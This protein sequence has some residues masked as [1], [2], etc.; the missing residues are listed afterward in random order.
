MPVPSSMPAPTPWTFAPTVLLVDN[1]PA[2]LDILGRRF[3]EKTSLGVLKLKTLGEA[4]EFLTQKKYLP[5]A[6]LTD[7]SFVPETQDGEHRLFNGLDLIDLS[8]KNFPDMPKY[9]N[10]VF[11][12]EREDLERTE[13][14]QLNIAHWFSKLTI[15]HGWEIHPWKRIERDLYHQAIMTN[16]YLL[17]QAEQA[18]FERS[19][20]DSDEILDW[21][22]T[23]IRPRRQTYLQQF[24]KK[25]AGYRVIKPIRVICEELEGGQVSADAPA[26]GLLLPGEGETVDD[27]LTDLGDSIIEQYEEFLSLGRDNIVGYAAKVFERIEEYVAPSLTG[28]VQA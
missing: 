13:E 11:C 6:L 22:R 19:S 28:G 20:L 25:W 16:K 12:Q 17:E 7:L 3:H 27:A 15:E 2:V 9:V 23:S 26:L 5:D 1:D 24:G 18:G 4:Y 21:I 8:Q 14:R 10:T